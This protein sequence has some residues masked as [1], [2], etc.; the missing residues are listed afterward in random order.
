[1]DIIASTG[2]NCI[3][4]KKGALDWLRVQNFDEMR[5]GWRNVSVKLNVP[6]LNPFN[7]AT[8]DDLFNGV[9]KGLQKKI[10]IKFGDTDYLV[11]TIQDILGLNSSTY[12]LSSNLYNKLI[13]IPFDGAQPLEFFLDKVLIAEL[14]K[15]IKSKLI[16]KNAEIAFTISGIG[17]SI[18]QIF[19]PTGYK[20]KSGNEDGAHMFKVFDWQ[21]AQVG[22][23]QN[24]FVVQEIAQRIEVK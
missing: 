19:I 8:T 4:Q 2:V 7:I 9:K 18:N 21:T 3:I 13:T 6:V 23:S 5:L 14:V 17:N 24:T 12:F 15:G 11:F 1:M 20:T 22:I 16:D 10:S